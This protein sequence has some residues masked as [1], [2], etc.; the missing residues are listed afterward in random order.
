MPSIPLTSTPAGKEAGFPSTGTLAPGL[1]TEMH[2]LG[3]QKA[4]AE[5]AF[6]PGGHNAKPLA[7]PSSV[8]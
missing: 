7:F 6:E 8:H 3:S 4:P 5:G 1:F 2:I